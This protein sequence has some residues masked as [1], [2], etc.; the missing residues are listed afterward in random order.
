MRPTAGQM[1]SGEGDRPCRRSPCRHSRCRSDRPVRTVW[2]TDCRWRRTAAARCSAGSYHSNLSDRDLA[3]WTECVGY[4][5]CYPA[6]CGDEHILVDI[7]RTSDPGLY[8]RYRCP[9]TFSGETHSCRDG[10]RPR[11]HCDEVSEL[12]GRSFGYPAGTT[13]RYYHSLPSMASSGTLERHASDLF[14]SMFGWSVDSL[15]TD[16]EVFRHFE[17]T[18]LSQIWASSSP[19]SA[20]THVGSSAQELPGHP[21]Q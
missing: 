1:A 19:W 7:G 16:D 3:A 9:E 14:I 11:G 15:R 2:A 4:A 6:P 8:N 17:D 18:P 21:V 10:C 5:S 20:L 12:P 13:T